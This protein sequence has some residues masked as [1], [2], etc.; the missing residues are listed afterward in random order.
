MRK[1]DKKPKIIEVKL[2][3]KL[4]SKYREILV[5]TLNK[6]ENLGKKKGIETITFRKKTIRKHFENSYYEGRI[7]KGEII[8]LNPKANFISALKTI[9]I[10]KEVKGLGEVKIFRE[11]EN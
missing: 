7:H 3:I 5:K 4:S 8:F 6:M 10:P 11:K 2:I 1:K 9:K